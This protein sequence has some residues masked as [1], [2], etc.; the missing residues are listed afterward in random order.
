MR[1]A[2]IGILALFAL[3]L[4]S[5]AEEEV[6]YEP[7]P[8]NPNARFLEDVDYLFY[9]LEHNFPFFNAAERAL[10]IDVAELKANTR[11][12]IERGVPGRTDERFLE[13]LERDFFSH[14]NGF[15]HLFTMDDWF[16]SFILHGFQLDSPWVYVLDNPASRSFYTNAP[17]FGGEGAEF[18]FPN[19]VVT[20]RI[21]EG[22]IASISIRS[23]NRDNIPH[24]TEIV[25]PF[26]ES[27]AEDYEHLIID[28][29]GNG[30]GA[31]AYFREAVM[32]FLIDE[33]VSYTYYFFTTNGDHVR[34]FY[35]ETPRTP[36]YFTA[37]P[38]PVGFLDR[39]P[40]LDADDA[41]LLHYHFYRKHTIYPSDYRVGFNGNIWLLVDERNFSA[42]DY[43]ATVTQQTGFAII[44][45]TPTGGAGIGFD[46]VVAV[47][48][49]TGIA[50]RF[51]GVYSV[52]HLGRNGYEF[53]TQPDVFN[54]E[55]MDALQTVL[56]LIEEGQYQ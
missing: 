44:V 42:A 16:Y 48:P 17:F 23:F 28:I 50:F 49:N 46:P 1:Y 12:T 33:P 31:S 32:Q 9:I 4:T 22:R 7:E 37:S 55:G 35:N 24:D 36:H 5:C 19:N 30:G 43:A 53:V 29:R 15:G 39:F 27:I 56:A 11:E 8:P 13:L 51:Q 21:E 3:L 47:L 10:G 38:I 54:R 34:M 2:L 14:F 6:F 41:E 45:G 20:E 18:V 52:D 26:L 40:Y 25:L